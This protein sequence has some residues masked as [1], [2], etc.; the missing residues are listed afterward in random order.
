MA[1]QGQGLAETGPDRACRAPMIEDQKLA[2]LSAKP[3]ATHSECRGAQKFDHI[4]AYVNERLALLASAKHGRTGRNWVTR[5][6]HTWA[7]QLGIYRLGG[8]VTRWSA[9][10]SR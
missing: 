1:P 4:D 3:D 5:Y 7:N 10:A 6:N 9:S 8:K 2:R